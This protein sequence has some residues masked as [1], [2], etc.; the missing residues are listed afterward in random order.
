MKT[1]SPNDAGKDYLK[2]TLRTLTV[3]LALLLC[4]IASREMAGQRDSKAVAIDAVKKLT[5]KIDRY[6]KDRHDDPDRI[7]IARK[8][9]PDS[10]EWKEF[11][12]NDE[13]EAFIEGFRGFQQAWIWLASTKPVFVRLAKWS[14]SGDWYLYTNY[15]FDDQGRILEIESD[16]R[17]APDD[18][19]VLRFRYFDQ[20]GRV[21]DDTVEY[22]EINPPE[23]KRLPGKPE[24]MESSIL[25]APVYLKISDLPFYS[26]LNL[27]LPSKKR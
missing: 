8:T 18:I 12:S 1:H 20:G 16:Y 2:K 7:F 22:Y 3:G 25:E 13:A 15:Y 5:A 27:D 6:A 23:N 11:R 9:A 4:L 24:N 19:S 14:G 21:L 26:L 17:T 10:W